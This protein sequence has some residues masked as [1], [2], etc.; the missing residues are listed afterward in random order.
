MVGAQEDGEFFAPIPSFWDFIADEYADIFSNPAILPECDIT[1]NINLIKGT[2]PPKPLI[3][4]ILSTEIVKVQSQ[5]VIY[6]KKDWVHP[7]TGIFGSPILFVCK[8][9]E[10]L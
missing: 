5:L 9:D 2:V 10:A 8:K 4:R 6:L 1:P 7:S 3:Y